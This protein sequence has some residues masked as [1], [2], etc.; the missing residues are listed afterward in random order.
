MYFPN[1]HFT[2]DRVSLRRATPSDA[3]PLFRIASN[4][5]VLRYMDWPA[6]GS[7]DEIKARLESESAKWESGKEF[8][9]VILE[10]ASE[11]VIGKISFRPKGQTTDFGY[12]LAPEFWGKGLAYEA[13]SLVLNWL[14]DQPEII[15]IWASADAENVKSHRVLERL[16]F[17]FE[18]IKPMA[19]Y[20]PHFGG[21]PR[22]TVIYAIEK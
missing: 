2:G 17:S 5:E 22:D 6:P 20:R 7:S 13:S 18:R 1:D 4:T 21:I 12:F 19:T 3:L 16:G 15:R 9:W 14:L 11:K 10:R 8:G